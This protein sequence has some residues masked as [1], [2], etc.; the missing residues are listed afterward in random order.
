[1]AAPVANLLACERQFV[2]PTVKIGEAVDRS[3]KQGALGPNPCNPFHPDYGKLPDRE[4]WVL[5]S[6]PAACQAFLAIKPAAGAVAAAFSDLDAARKTV[7]SSDL[8]AERARKIAIERLVERYSQATAALAGLQKS[9]AQSVAEKLSLAKL[10]GVASKT[11]DLLLPLDRL[12]PASELSPAALNEADRKLD[13]ADCSGPREV[14][15]PS[16]ALACQCARGYLAQ[17]GAALLADMAPAVRASLAA[18]TPGVPALDRSGR[19]QSFLFRQ[20][21]PITFRLVSVGEGDRPKL[22]A[23]QTLLALHPHSKPRGLSLELKAMNKGSVALSFSSLGVPSTVKVSTSSS[24]AGWAG[25]IAEGTKT[26]RDEYKATVEAL[27]AIQEKQREL[28]LS[29]LS[30]ELARLKKEK[31]LLDQSIAVEVAEGSYDSLVNRQKL[32]NDLALLESQL[33]LKIAQ[34]TLDLRAATQTIAAELAR[35]LQE[36]ELVKKRLELAEAQ[37]RK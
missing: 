35:V 8:A 22:G 32:E 5:G 19:R 7:P 33:R 6:S 11:E 27:V 31:E 10:A 9:L 23:A 16:A 21:V 24:A 37:A 26:L 1:L 15:A 13:L 12:C 25:A 2:E 14:G 4:R 20:P 34:E 30:D 3:S 18:G 17:K 28:D 36:L 29:D